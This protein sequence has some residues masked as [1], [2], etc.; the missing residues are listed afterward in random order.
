M[1]FQN[2]DKRMVLKPIHSEIKKRNLVSF[3]TE[4]NTQGDMI[5]GNVYDGKQHIPF[6]T[7]GEFL[8]IVR[9]LSL[10]HGR[11]KVTLCA[12]NLEYDMVNAFK[13]YY[14]RLD[15]MYA[16]RLINFT[17]KDSNVRGLDTLNHY[18]EGVK[19]Q[20]ERLGIKKTFHPCRQVKSRRS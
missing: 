1:T 6:E 16:G 18:Q 7:P 12:T 9:D 14:N 2:D 15:L 17:V 20:G 4:D 11:T 13:G 8:S 5:Y 3:D 19:K 10:K